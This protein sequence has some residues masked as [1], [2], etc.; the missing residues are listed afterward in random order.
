MNILPTE[1]IR[2]RR[3]SLV[4]VVLTLALSCGGIFRGLTRGRDPAA[5]QAPPDL[6]VRRFGRWTCGA[7]LPQGRPS[8]VFD[9]RLHFGPGKAWHLVV[10]PDGFTQLQIVEHHGRARQGCWAEITAEELAAL[11]RSVRATSLCER[12]DD[13]RTGETAGSFDVAF[14]FNGLACSR[15]VAVAAWHRTAAGRRFTDDIQAW[16]D[17]VSNGSFRGVESFAMS[18]GERGHA[19]TTPVAKGRLTCDPDRETIYSSG[20]TWLLEYSF[21]KGLLWERSLEISARGAVAL[22][23]ASFQNSAHMSCTGRLTD[24]ELAEVEN[25]IETGALC[26][27]PTSHPPAWDEYGYLSVHRNNLQCRYH[28]IRQEDLTGSHGGR[29]FDQLITSLV[30][31]LVGPGGVEPFDRQAG[32]LFQGRALGS[33]ANLATSPPAGPKDAPLSWS[34]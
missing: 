17:R 32:L 20:D 19:G 10:D 18:G 3:T 22:D 4:L 27:L 29:R 21:Q 5:T 28:A 2:V 8:S 15:H 12:P 11:E 31:K 6:S 23:L 26:D 9:L 25:V 16:L 14:Q 1:S 30:G 24:E 13:A 33:G 34:R 7:E